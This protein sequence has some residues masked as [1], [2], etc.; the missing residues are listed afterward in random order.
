MSFN[1]SKYKIM[2]V[3][4]HNPGY[5]YIMRG[6]KLSIS[7]EKRDIGVAVTRNLKPSVQCSRAAGR[8]TS[9]LGQIK[10]NFHF[11]SYSYTHK[12]YV[13]LHLQ[14]AVPACTPWL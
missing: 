13:C 8:V 12:Q 4:P 1:S 2:H 11:T 14:F 3:G 9:V 10:L 5:E 7:E 6:M